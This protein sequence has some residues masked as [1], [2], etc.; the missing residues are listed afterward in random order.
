MNQPIEP[1]PQYPAGAPV[2]EP[3]AVPRPPQVRNAVRAMYAGAAASI[4]GVVLEI[5]TVSATKTAIEKRS[6]HLTASQLNSTEH[7]LI[8]GFVVS[9]LVGVAA[10]IM[11]A[12]ACRNGSNWARI[13][14]TVLFALATIDTLLGVRAPLAVAVRAW[15]PVI[16]LAGLAAVI[17]L[18]QG[19]ST[20]YFKGR[21]QP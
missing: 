8:I 16:W 3:S 14:G 11:L 9:G 18:W 7:A 10:W 13:T 1:L 6:R 21:R 5:L 12:R 19:A 2:P 17:F 4:V 20:A 15:W